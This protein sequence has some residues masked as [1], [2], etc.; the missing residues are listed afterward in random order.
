MQAPLIGALAV[1][2]G[3]V[4][5]RH[6]TDAGLIIGNDAF[7]SVVPPPLAVQVLS[8]GRLTSA[9]LQTKL[10]D[11]YKRRAADPDSGESRQAV[12]R[13]VAFR[14][15]ARTNALF[16]DACLSPSPTPAVRSSTTTSLFPRGLRPLGK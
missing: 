4:T 12:V 7:W 13:V 6:D 10:I 5:L 15:A 16:G 11:M 1:D 14:G 2:S 3:V 8:E 9:A